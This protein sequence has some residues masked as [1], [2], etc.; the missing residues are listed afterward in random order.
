MQKFCFITCAY[1]SGNIH[2]V[3][4]KVTDCIFKVSRPLLFVENQDDLLILYRITTNHLFLCHFQIANFK[5]RISFTL[6]V[7]SQQSLGRAARR[8][9]P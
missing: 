7:F 2:L 8:F 4:Y 1:I 6:F 5:N 3:T 9:K